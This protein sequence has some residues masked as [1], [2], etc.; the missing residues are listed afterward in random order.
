MFGIIKPPVSLV[1]TDGPL[2]LPPKQDCNS[3]SRPKTARIR[4]YVV[5]P[6]SPYRRTALTKLSDKRNSRVQ[7]G[8]EQSG[9]LGCFSDFCAQKLR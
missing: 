1:K 9:R 3:C 6:H 7:F 4:S 2:C 5:H 8:T